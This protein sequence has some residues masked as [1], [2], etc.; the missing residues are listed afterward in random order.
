[1]RLAALDVAA[2]FLAYWNHLLQNELFAQVIHCFGTLVAYL[3]P[4][5]LI[6]VPVRFLTKVPSFVFRKLLHAIAFT[7]VSL[8]ILSA[9]SWQAAALTSMTIAGLAYPIL[10]ALENRPW[11]SML[12][13]EKRPSEVKSS[14]L[15]LFFMFAAV[16]AVCWGVFDQPHLAATAILMWGVGDAAAALVGIPFGKHKVKAKLADGKKSWE[17]SAAMLAVSF[18]VGFVTLS[19][20]QELDLPRAL[21][22]VTVG[23]VLGTATELFSPSEYDTVT[24]PVVIA[25]VLL[26]L[27]SV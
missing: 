6:V 25:A 8:M 27:G 19:F 26:V 15:L 18:L 9:E 24:V 1:M 2:Q 17:G 21:V 16:A 12:F 14:L 22:S 11:F 23:A 10:A 4:C 7:C 3:I 20:A 5:L 13:V